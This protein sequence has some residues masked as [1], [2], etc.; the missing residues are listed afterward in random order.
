MVLIS[1][2]QFCYIFFLDN[3]IQKEEKNINKDHKEEKNNKDERINQND[4]N[5]LK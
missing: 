1:L 2:C 3:Y 4:N 5:N